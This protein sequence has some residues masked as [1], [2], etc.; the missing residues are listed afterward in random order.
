CYPVAHDTFTVLC[1]TSVPE[2]PGGAS[3]MPPGFV[4]QDP[5]GM[6]PM[7]KPIRSYTEFWPFYLA[8]HRHPRTR[9]LHMLG[10]VLALAFLAVAVA[11]ADWRWLAASLVSGYGFA[12]TAHLLVERNRPATVRHP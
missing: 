11:T 12:W 7:P 3:P 8:E 5:P 6:G 2:A 1:L 4:F 10:T 9:A